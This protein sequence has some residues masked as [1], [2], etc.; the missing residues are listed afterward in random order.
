[1]PSRDSDRPPPDRSRRKATPTRCR[2]GA[3]DTFWPTQRATLA[4]P[5]AIIIW[6][7]YP[8]STP[9]DHKSA[10]STD[11]RRAAFDTLPILPPWPPPDRFDIYR[12]QRHRF[13]R[14]PHPTTRQSRYERLPF[15][16]SD[17]DLLQ[18]VK[19]PTR[20]QRERQEQDIVY[21]ETPAFWIDTPPMRHSGNQSF[22]V[23]PRTDAFDHIPL[24]HVPKGYHPELVGDISYGPSIYAT[25]QMM[26]D[27]SDDTR[28]NVGNLFQKLDVD[29]CH[30]LLSSSLIRGQVLYN[31]LS[32]ALD[33]TPPISGS[34]TLCGEYFDELAQKDAA[35]YNV[36]PHGTGPPHQSKQEL[37]PH[38]T[39]DGIT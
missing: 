37:Q 32:S 31:I 9:R 8:R 35:Y 12:S 25:R 7:I 16:M 23:D 14:R 22:A 29:E 4:T 36:L 18:K 15:D 39:Q 20:R 26:A 13:G 30:R 24:R 38:H 34:S 28:N 19:S 1:M 21:Q 3:A 10:A 33:A 11:S 5:S 2:D 17:L 6:S 27:P